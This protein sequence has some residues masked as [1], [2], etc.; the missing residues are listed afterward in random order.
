MTP[1]PSE[2]A[3][4][5]ADTLAALDAYRRAGGDVLPVGPVPGLPP[6]E[7]FPAAALSGDAPPRSRE[8]Q[9]SYSPP[10]EAPLSYTPPRPA[11]PRAEP[12][13]AESAAPPRP[14]P[15]RPAP[16]APP[17]PSEPAAAPAAGLFGARWARVVEGPE[18]AYAALQAEVQACRA[19]AR[20]EGRAAVV[21]GQGPARALLI[22]VTDPP[23]AQAEQAGVPLFGEAASMLEKMLLRVVRVEQREVQVVPIVRCGS[24]PADARA[25]AAC[26]GYLDR[27]IALTRPRA[28]LVMGEQA[29]TALGLPPNGTW[30]TVAGVAAIATF[31]PDRLIAQPD[32]KKQ[33]MAHLLEL[34]QRV[35]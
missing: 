16:D 26:R 6:A 17:P 31:H 5:I 18:P 29:R 28:L 12:P 21:V 35:G 19:C 22:V 7:P 10:R 1:D 14:E 11:P 34:A 27:Q 3:A 15:P 23:D 13:R 25:L 9:P 4:L 2:L 32:L 20:C 33:T 24:G 8:A 30:G